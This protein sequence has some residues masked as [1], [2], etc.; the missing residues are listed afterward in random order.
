MTSIVQCTSEM[1]LLELLKKMLVLG[2]GTLIAELPFSIPLVSTFN[3]HS[4][5]LSH[6][7]FG[8]S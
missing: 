1:S 2:S 4:E 8:R 6:T 5:K 3:L 7:I